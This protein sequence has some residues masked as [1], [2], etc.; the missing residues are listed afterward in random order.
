[1]SIIPVILMREM[2]KK[3]DSVTQTVTRNDVTPVTFRCPRCDRWGVLAQGTV[4]PMCEACKAAW[5][6]K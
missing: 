3:R 2:Q 1:M 6:V 5:G 4:A